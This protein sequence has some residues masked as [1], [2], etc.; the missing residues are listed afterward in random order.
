MRHEAHK[1]SEMAITAELTRLLE[2]SVSP[3]AKLVKE[4]PIMPVGL[5]I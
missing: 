5:R 4:A 1:P 3:L 2:I